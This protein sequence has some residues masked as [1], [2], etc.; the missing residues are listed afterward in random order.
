MC[1]QFV[2]VCVCVCVC[3]FKLHIGYSDK[4]IFENKI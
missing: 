2:C 3:V 1:L 4:K